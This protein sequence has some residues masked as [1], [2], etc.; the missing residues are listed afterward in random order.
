MAIVF[1]SPRRKQ[2]TFI[3]TILGIFVFLILGVFLIMFFMTP[4]TVTQEQPFI[5]PNINLNLAILDS[6]E[7]KKLLPLEEIE[8]QYIYTAKD[9]EGKEVSGKISAVSEQLAKEALENDKLIILK[10]E[11][12]I[13]GRDNPFNIYYQIEVNKNTKT[14]K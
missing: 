3:L 1:V 4:K 13:S 14:S 11:K 6:N 12:E 10:L 8:R 5:K 9:K 2:L 7:L